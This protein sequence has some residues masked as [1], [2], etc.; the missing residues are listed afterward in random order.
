MTGTTPKTL[1]TSNRC[2]KAT[3]LSLEDV[4]RACHDLPDLDSVVL[5]VALPATS[6]RTWTPPAARYYVSYEKTKV[7]DTVYKYMCRDLR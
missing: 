4:R 3:P 1:A 2:D 7:I 5:N 6:P